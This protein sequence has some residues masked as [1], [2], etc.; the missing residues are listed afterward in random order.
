MLNHRPG[1]LLTTA[2]LEAEMDHSIVGAGVKGSEK[3]EVLFPERR[4]LQ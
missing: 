3:A 2:F 1:V 4:L